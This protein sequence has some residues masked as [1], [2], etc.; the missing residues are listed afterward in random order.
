MALYLK[1]LLTAP[2]ERTF[3]FA[4]SFASLSR[5]YSNKYLP[6]IHW[7]TQVSRKYRGQFYSENPKQ[8]LCEGSDVIWTVL[9]ITY[10]ITLR[11]AK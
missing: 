3:D 10:N 11:T 9:A 2:A 1:G 4:R 7:H 8:T 6:M 5:K